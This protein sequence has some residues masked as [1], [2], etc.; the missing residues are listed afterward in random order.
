MERIAVSV[1]EAAEM[2]GMCPK[3]F[4]NLPDR[5]ISRRSRRETVPL[6]TWRVCG[7]G[8][9]GRPQE[10]GRRYDRYLLPV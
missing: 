8:S 10:K 7:S 9:G 3:K 1:T 6:F 2:L 5:R 4:T